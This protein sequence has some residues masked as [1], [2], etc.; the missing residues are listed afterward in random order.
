MIEQQLSKATRLKIVFADAFAEA[1][2]AR[3]KAVDIGMISDL[4]DRLKAKQAFV[5]KFLNV[6][7]LGPD[8]HKPT[9]IPQGIS[10]SFL[11]WTLIIEKG[12]IDSLIDFVKKYAFNTS[13][14][15][16]EVAHS[17]ELAYVQA[18]TP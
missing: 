9:I 18:E 7:F 8:K 15:P 1:Y 14:D 6:W 16:V 13:R 10:V 5:S 11:I 17:F 2:V 4:G 12:G 3:L